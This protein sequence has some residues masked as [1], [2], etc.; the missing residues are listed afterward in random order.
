MGRAFQFSG[1]FSCLTAQQVGRRESWE[2]EEEERVMNFKCLT[3]DLHRLFKERNFHKW[4]IILE[5]REKEGGWGGRVFMNGRHE[6][7][8][9]F[10]KRQNNSS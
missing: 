4:Q 7:E 1:G 6:R 2:L 9:C 10:E 5:P 3:W 8:D